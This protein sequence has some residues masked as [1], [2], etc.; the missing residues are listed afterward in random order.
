[1]SKPIG[2]QLRRC[3]E[4]KYPVGGLIL[5]DINHIACPECG[6][7]YDPHRAPESKGKNGWIIG[8]GIGTVLSLGF[9]FAL[10]CLLIGFFI[11]MVMAFNF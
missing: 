11:L 4:C 9:V 5:D 10:C 1:M 8:A 2:K 6:H 3:P 7:Y